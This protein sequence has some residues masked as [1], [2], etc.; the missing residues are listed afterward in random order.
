MIVSRNRTAEKAAGAVLLVLEP[1]VGPADL[2]DRSR[3]RL[4]EMAEAERVLLVLPKRAGFPDQTR[5]RWLGATFPA[6]EGLANGVLDAA[7]LGGHVARPA[8]S[9][10]AWTGRL[11]APELAEP[12][13]VRGSVLDPVVQTDQGI[14]V[15]ERVEGDAHLLVLSDPDVIA[16]HGLGRGG[17]AELALALLDRLDPGGRAVVVVDET[18]HGHEL[19]PS[20]PRELLRWPLV[21]ATLQAA[22]ALALLAWAALVRFGRPRAAPPALATGKDVLVENT[23]DLL[24]HG[25]HVAPA[26]AAYW[27]AAREQI[28]H[29]LRPP[30]ERSGDLDRWLR[31]LAAARG[32]AERLA[33]LERRVAALRGRRGHEEEALRAALD[34]HA[35]REEMTDGAAAD[36]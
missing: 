15:G 31:G 36:R 32:R 17:N 35:F 11:P 30:G 25:V 20:L 9:I 3:T 10:G 18:L 7:H 27:R 6:P 2:D 24:R 21:L 13:L 12:Q 19:Q 14:L 8:A 26:V 22:L 23:A 16:T 1:M 33:A 5:P 29:A 4:A 28:A 34:V